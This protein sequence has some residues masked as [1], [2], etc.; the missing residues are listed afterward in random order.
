MPKDNRSPAG[1]DAVANWYHGWVG[2]KGSDHHQK[3]AI[4]AI[5]DL[6]QLEPNETL[7]DM[8]CG[9]GVFAPYAQQHGTGYTGIDISERLI[10]I[11]RGQHQGTFIVGDARRL[12]HNH[13]I[14]A[15]SFDACAFLLSIQDMN[16]LEDVMNSAA[17]ALRPGGRIAILMTHPCFRIPRLS[18]WGYD[19]GRKLQF[20]RI[21]RY[22]TPQRVPMKTYEGK[23]SGNTV[24][25]HRPLSAYVNALGESGFAIDALREI[26]TYKQPKDKATRRAEQEI[27]LF[28]A[29]RARKL[30]VLE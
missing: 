17:Y 3:L 18:G 25:F 14:Q 15:Q 10:K 13:S 19:E 30:P 4:P 16:P 26:T 9:S 12:P 23:Q 20:R 2:E 24:S 7:L 27:P 6:L 22:L 28:L 21:D 1:W 11:A 29:L 5:I 8:G